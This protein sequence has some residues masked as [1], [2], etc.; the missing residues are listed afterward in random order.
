M[1]ATF[2]ALWRLI[3]DQIR[4]TGETVLLCLESIIWTRSA[5]R[6]IKEIVNQFYI[7]TFKA[8]TGVTN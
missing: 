1:G 3:E 5:P 2:L 4:I 6:Q 8:I 7:C